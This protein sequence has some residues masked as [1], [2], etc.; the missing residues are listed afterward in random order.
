MV[1]SI[2]YIG[3]ILKKMHRLLLPI[4]VVLLARAETLRVGVVSQQEMEQRLRSAPARNQ[5][6]QAAIGVMFRSAG[7]PPESLEMRPLKRSKFSN[8]VC[9][10]A[11]TGP[12]VIVVGGH[13]DH[14]KAG[15]GVIDNWSG[16]SMLANLI[17]SL[18]SE[19]R[20]HTF[21][22]AAFAE[23]EA[24]LLGA[25]AFARALS[26]ADVEHVKAMVNIDSLGLGPVVVWRSRA[27]P[28][29]FDAAQAVA[30]AI[31]FRLDVVD[32][33]GAAE[34][35]SEPFRQRNIPVIDFHSLHPDTMH[36]LH[37][38]DDSFQAVQ[39]QGYT[40][41]FRVIANFLAWIDA[42]FDVKLP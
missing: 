1:Q 20:R 39:M 6:R 29:L 37:S 28:S 21:V 2:F 23:E 24:G 32:M 10:M 38:K 25:Q 4:V 19:T 41:S 42:K 16:A 33:D 34:S 5:Q 27:S 12:D 22:F 35:D 18:G 26:K 17:Q 13:F 3:A 15:D 9:T 40:D 30:A 8:V 36:I 11:G 7:C 14:S 31:D